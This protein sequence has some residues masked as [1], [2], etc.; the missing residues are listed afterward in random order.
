[1][2]SAEIENLLVART[3]FAVEA[4]ASD[5]IEMLREAGLSFIPTGSPLQWRNQATGEVVEVF[6]TLAASVST[7]TTDLAPPNDMHTELFV[8]RAESGADT[9]ASVLHRFDGQ[10]ANGGF[11]QLIENCGTHFAR[12]ASVAL[13]TVGARAAAR[14]TKNAIARYEAAS[15]ALQESRCLWDALNRLDARYYRMGVDLPALYALHTAAQEDGSR[16]KST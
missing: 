7:P 16:E 1:M 13:N 6:C 15:E 5:C 3:R 4:A 2:T 10:M 11:S 12:E 9:L 8:A 14:L